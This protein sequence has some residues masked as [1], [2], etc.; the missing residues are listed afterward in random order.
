MIGRLLRLLIIGLF[1]V[2]IYRCVLRKRN[3]ETISY[4][5]NCLALILLSM[6]ALICLLYVLK[7]D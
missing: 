7:G 3:R 1:L 5:V 2:V 6:A 4:W